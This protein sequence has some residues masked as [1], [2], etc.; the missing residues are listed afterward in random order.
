MYF[1]HVFK[2]KVASFVTYTMYST[3]HTMCIVHVTIKAHLLTVLES[4]WSCKMELKFENDIKKVLKSIK[5]DLL[6]P[7]E[8]L[9]RKYITEL[10]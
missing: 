8:T 2:G 6:I 3:L 7:A 10:V 4:G 5:L 9:K 1:M